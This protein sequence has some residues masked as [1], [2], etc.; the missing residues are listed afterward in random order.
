MYAIR[1]IRSGAAFGRTLGAAVL[2]ALLLAASPGM[3]QVISPQTLSAPTLSVTP[4]NGQVTLT[5]TRVD[6]ALFYR[7][8][9][10]DDGG[11]SYGS[12][13]VNPV[14]AGEGGGLGRRSVVTGLTN[15]TA[16]TF[17]V[18][19]GAHYLDLQS[20]KLVYYFS[21]PSNAVTVTPAG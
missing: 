9:R 15:G 4:G 13:V 19:A 5:W 3:S 6:G 2:V 18:A 21:N 7:L 12:W 10:S 8:R 11:A 17:Q 20:G 1:R 16:Y 14:H